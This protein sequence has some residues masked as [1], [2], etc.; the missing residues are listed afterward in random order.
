MLN[1]LNKIGKLI[2]NTP[3]MPLR[4][5]N[6]IL[7]AKLEYNNFSGSSKD[8][9]AFSV[10]Y[11]AMKAR[12]INRQTTVVTSSS[13]NFAIAM[14][15]ICKYLKVK[16]IPVVDPNI[17]RS[18]ENYLRIISHKVVKV[19]EMDSTG[20][21]LLTRIAK[22]KEMCLDLEGAFNAD[23]YCDPNN[24]RGY[25]GLGGEILHSVAD[26][27][28][29]FIAVSSGGAITGISRYVKEHAARVR[30]IGVDVQ[31]SVIFGQP[32]ERRYIS[33]IGSS[34]VPP[35]LKEAI[36]DEVVHLSQTD[37][38]KGCH[39][40]LEEQLIFGGASSGA[41]YLAA[42]RYFDSKKS[43]IK[44]RA[45]LIF[46]DRGF[47]YLD[48]VYNSSWEQTLAFRNQKTNAIP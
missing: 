8:R 44:P 16:F 11:H 34:M 27:D 37:I 10:V 45:V 14:G 12:Q 28:Y 22:V 39:Q 23:Q 9:A 2:G 36:I 20:G 5:R 6:A 29:I 48:T 26:L 3:I 1:E 7:Q 41:V 40:L 4:F 46:P 15:T 25:F 42:K 17:N 38:V 47:A 43:I 18:Y 32:P 30:I 35:I 19:D 21:Y 24:Y 33:G 13:G 31:G